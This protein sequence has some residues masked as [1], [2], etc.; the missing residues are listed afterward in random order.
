MKITYTPNPL[1]TVIELDELDVE[2][3]RYSVLRKILQEKLFHIRY[4]NAHG[5]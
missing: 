4:K 3:L 1:N 5:F 2:R